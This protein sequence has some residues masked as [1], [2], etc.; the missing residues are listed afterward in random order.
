M[1][2]YSVC[3]C[4]CHDVKCISHYRSN[5]QKSVKIAVLKQLDL[6]S[7]FKPLPSDPLSPPHLS[8]WLE[9]KLSRS[10]VGRESGAHKGAQVFQT[11][12]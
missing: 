3:S 10:L 4:V 5:G 9:V 12:P 2:M 7:S 11:L 1:H 6:T 8:L